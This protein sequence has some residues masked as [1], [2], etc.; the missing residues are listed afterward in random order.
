VTFRPVT[1]LPT[2]KVGL[3]WRVDNDDPRIQYFIGIVRGR[4]ERSSRG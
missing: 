3:A 4:T 2:T 1:D